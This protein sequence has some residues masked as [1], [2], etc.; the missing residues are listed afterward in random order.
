MIEEREKFNV[1]GEDLV[2]QEAEEKATGECKFSS[3]TVLPHMLHAKVLRSPHAHAKVKRI[4]TEKAKRLP[5][6]KAVITYEDVPKIPVM[7]S[8]LLLPSVMNYDHHIL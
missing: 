2:K 8:Y 4:D 6:V 3:D 7:H 1:I 5:G